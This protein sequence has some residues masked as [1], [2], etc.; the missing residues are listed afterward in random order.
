MSV[1]GYGFAPSSIDGFQLVA[2]D[3][4]W[5]VYEE[6]IS[7]DASGRFDL[8]VNGSDNPSAQGNFTYQKTD[9]A[10]AILSYSVDG[11]ISKF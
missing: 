9:V 3:D 4:N 5:P 1:I 7:F 2:D 8:I 11:R 6:T 10:Q